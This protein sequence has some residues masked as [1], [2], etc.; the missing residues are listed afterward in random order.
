M[1]QKPPGLQ[2]NW[3]TRQLNGSEVAGHLKEQDL[4]VLKYARTFRNRNR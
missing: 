2:S 4:N 3:K 1:K